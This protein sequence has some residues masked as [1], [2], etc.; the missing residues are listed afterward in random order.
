MSE[1]IFFFLFENYSCLFL[2]SSGWLTVSTLPIIENDVIIT[3]IS[4]EM[5]SA[6]G[7]LLARSV[8]NVYNPSVT[9][10]RVFRSIKHQ[11]AEWDKVVQMRV[12]ENIDED[13]D[14]MYARTTLAIAGGTLSETNVADRAN[15]SP[16]NENVQATESTLDFVLLRS[17]RH[18]ESFDGKHDTFIVASRSI[19]FDAIPPANE[20]KSENEASPAV[21]RSHVFPTGFFI[22]EDNGKVRVTYIAQLGGASLNIVKDQI[23]G[24]SSAYFEVLKALYYYQLRG[25]CEESGLV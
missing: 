10:E 18:F 14:I 12:V 9:G 1:L 19:L 15:S 22:K 2:A 25:D 20:C 3:T 16:A 17:C 4:L 6:N 23:S 21:T 8:L 11:R 7:V 24:R 5:N 13:N